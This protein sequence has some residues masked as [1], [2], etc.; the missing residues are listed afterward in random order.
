MNLGA[1]IIILKRVSK[2]KPLYTLKSLES[3][4]S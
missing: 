4:D 3:I 2:M 1:C